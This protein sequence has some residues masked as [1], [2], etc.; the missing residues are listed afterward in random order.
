MPATYK[1]CLKTGCFQDNWKIAKIV[2]IIKPGSENGTDTSMY[3]PISLLNTEGKA[4]EN[5]LS[6]R[7]IHQLQKTENVN[8]IQYRFTPQ[9]V[10]WTPPWKLNNTQ[11]PTQREEEWQYWLIFTYMELLTRRVGR[12]YYNGCMKQNATE[13]FTTKSK[14]TCNKGKQL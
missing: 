10:Q 9:K 1:A 14:T 3:R 13:N 8:G 4:L 2:P 7:I 5:L 6:K 11:N 12:R